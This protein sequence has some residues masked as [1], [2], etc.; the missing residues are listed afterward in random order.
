MSFVGLEA[1][2]KYTNN[3]HQ[4]QPPKKKEDF[5]VFIGVISYFDET[6]PNRA[7]R[8]RV[9]TSSD[10]KTNYSSRRMAASWHFNRLSINLLASRCCD[11]TR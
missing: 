9:S 10:K 1:D 5:A 6:T 11:H 4:R 8:L 3:I 2:L 7:R